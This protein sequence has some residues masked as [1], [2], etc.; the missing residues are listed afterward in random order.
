MGVLEAEH[1][2]TR[3]RLNAVQRNWRGIETGMVRLADGFL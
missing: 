2:A 3:K 1:P